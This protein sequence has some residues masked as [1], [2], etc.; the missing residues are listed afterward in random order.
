M[1]CGPQAGH[2][3]VYLASYPR[4]DME[5]N[6]IL[7][8]SRWEQLNAPFEV[9]RLDKMEGRNFLNKMELLMAALTGQRNVNI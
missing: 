1:R 4:T 9:V 8:D 6:R 7:Q 3:K 2:L 5:K